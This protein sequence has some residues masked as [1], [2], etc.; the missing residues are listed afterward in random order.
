MSP[1]VDET[2]SETETILSDEEWVEAK[3]L[4]ISLVQGA[5]DRPE[6]H[7]SYVRQRIDAALDCNVV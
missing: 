5:L 1:A 4:A 2:I 3:R 6:A 7:L